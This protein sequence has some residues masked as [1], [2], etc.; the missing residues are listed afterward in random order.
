MWALSPIYLLG[1]AWPAG[2]GGLVRSL[3]PTPAAQHSCRRSPCADQDTLS[4]GDFPAGN[5]P[6]FEHARIITMLDK[7]PVTALGWR[8][9]WG[10]SDD[11]AGSKAVARRWTVMRDPRL[12]ISPGGGAGGGGGSAGGFRIQDS[13]WPA[14]G[15]GK[16]EGG[17]PE[18]R[19]PQPS[20]RR[21]TRSR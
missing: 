13:G 19:S 12:V 5:V 14:R 17:L 4:L 3:I 20:I 9:G 16:A 8:A 1:G 21:F 6:E 11:H 15:G 7:L 2:H 18:N 10:S